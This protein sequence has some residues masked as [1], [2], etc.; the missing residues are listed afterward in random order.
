MLAW[1]FE[2]ASETV[3][4]ELIAKG[5]KDAYAWAQETE[6]CGEGTDEVC[7]LASQRKEEQQYPGLRSRD[8]ASMDKVS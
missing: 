2:P 3:L 8:A 1:A 5:R 4:M 6:A 7:V